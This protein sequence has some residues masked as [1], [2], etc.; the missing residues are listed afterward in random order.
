MRMTTKEDNVKDSLIRE[1][2][3]QEEVHVSCKKKKKV[4]GEYQTITLQKFTLQTDD[5]LH[6]LFTFNIHL[7]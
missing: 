2:R 3:E 4:I 1:E 7:T 5:I 6:E